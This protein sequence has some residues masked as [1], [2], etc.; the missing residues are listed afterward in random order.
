MTDE[1]TPQD[2]AAMPPASAGSHGEPFAWAAECAPGAWSFTH[3]RH[4]AARWPQS[5]TIPLYRTPQTCP[6][7]V[8]R[9]TLHC[10]LTPFTLTDEERAAIE[11][12]L[13]W[14]QWCEDNSQIGDIGRK[15]IAT[16][17]GLLERQG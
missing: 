16:L 5:E 12:D 13:S 2:S 17:R 8:G 4:V 6:H 3:M 7:V 11:R 10:S 9:T 1:T 15:D 14:L